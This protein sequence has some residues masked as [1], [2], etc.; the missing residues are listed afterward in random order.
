MSSVAPL[1]FFRHQAHVSESNYVQQLLQLALVNN[2]IIENQN[3]RQCF[4][5]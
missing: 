4:G 1:Q 3:G 2:Q 5:N